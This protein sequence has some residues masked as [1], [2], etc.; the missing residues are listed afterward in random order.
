[1]DA[2]KQAWQSDQPLSVHGWIYA[3]E[4]GLL[5]DLGTTVSNEAE[6]AK[7]LTP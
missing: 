3:I 6:Y 2:I 4:D 1:M 5:K 7:L